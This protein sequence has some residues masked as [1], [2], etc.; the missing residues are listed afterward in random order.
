MKLKLT[1]RDIQIRD[2]NHFYSIDFSDEMIKFLGHFDIRTARMIFEIEEY[3]T[4][5]VYRTRDEW[6]HDMVIHYDHDID[7]IMGYF[8]IYLTADWPDEQVILKLCWD[9]RYNDL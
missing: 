8:G 1:S 3:S 5:Y 4:P 9:G 7:D 6:I 2:N